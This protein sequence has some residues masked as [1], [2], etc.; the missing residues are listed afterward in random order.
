MALGPGDTKHFAVLCCIPPAYGFGDL[1]I[2]YRSYG[3]VPAPSGRGALKTYSSTA[4][5]RFDCMEVATSDW[6]NFGSRM[7]AEV[8]LKPGPKGP[9]WRPV[10][11]KLSTEITPYVGTVSSPLAPNPGAL[12]VLTRWPI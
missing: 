1:D 2:F 5:A 4:E 11:A 10:F 9:Y 3:P 12:S 6:F 8:W 7:S